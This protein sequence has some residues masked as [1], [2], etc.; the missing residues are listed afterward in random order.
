VVSDISPSAR[1][2]QAVSAFVRQELG[3]PVGA[4]IGY[5][6]ILLEDARREGLE[7]FVS[8]LV[9]MRTAA[10]DLLALIDRI[11]GGS[12][13]GV[14]PGRL[15]H[16]LRT[17]LNAI[18]GYS[19]LILEEAR[20]GGSGALV[21][22]LSAVL[23]LAGRLLSEIDRIASFGEQSGE[24]PA[25]QP[26]E[27]VRQVLRTVEPLNPVEAGQSQVPSS[28][29]LVVDDDPANRDLLSRRLEREGHCVAAAAEGTTAL[30]LAAGGAFD[31]VLL[32]MMM[33]GLSGFEVLSRL[34]ADDRFRDLPVIMISALDEL[35]S[36]VRCI[37]AGAEDYLPKP[38]NPVLLRARINASL[39]KKRLRD[40]ERAFAEEL[41]AE[42]ERSEALLRNILPPTIIQRLRDGERVIAD[43]VAEATIL[44]SD[45]VDFTALTARLP[46]ER[47]IALLGAL[48]AD[49][50]ALAARL[51]L[52]KIK[53]IGDGYMVAGGLPEP[54]P[55][56]AAA[57]AE[58]A[59]Q[60]HELA[61]A[62][63]AE[64]DETVQLRIGVHSGE[65]F[66]GVIGTHKFVYDVW[67]DTVNTAKRIETYGAP[68]RTHLSA[69]TRDLLG[70]AYQFEPRRPLEVKGKGQIK[71]FFLT[72][73]TT[74]LDQPQTQKLARLR[75]Q[76]PPQQQN[77]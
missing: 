30:Q 14:D 16:D 35:D 68:G 70:D 52:E 17:P 48:F 23:G 45:L 5:L 9:R 77:F 55:D 37:E 74:H 60:M 38:F 1:L 54:R 3:S 21:E 64:F 27:I 6:D 62:V 40:S 31:L 61:A 33:P 12:A 28:R 13:G 59:L 10:G 8:D 44:F 71:T 51:G 42:K 36:T 47:T 58:M 34:K 22:D 65:L 7:H 20:E 57:V 53:T 56:H 73:R 50:D 32:D 49:F 41:Q 67:G 25:P 24:S 46:P 26:I 63:A 39:E 18:K 43:R 76:G 29:V 72:G 4:I 75:S 2:D 11:A 66:A 19:E 15:R 69:V